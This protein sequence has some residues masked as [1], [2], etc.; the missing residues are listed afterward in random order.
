MQAKATNGKVAVLWISGSAGA[1][2]SLDRLGEGHLGDFFFHGDVTLHRDNRQL[3]TSLR[4]KNY[5]TIQVSACRIDAFP[6][7]ASSVESNFTKPSSTAEAG[8]LFQDAFIW[9]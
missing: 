9:D 4:V 2:Q 1:Q 3:A 7:A 8:Q 6:Q 5:P